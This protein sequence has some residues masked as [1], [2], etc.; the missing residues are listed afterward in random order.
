[1]NENAN[2]LVKQEPQETGLTTPMSDIDWGNDAGDG[3][4][5]NRDFSQRLLLIPSIIILQSDTPF[6]KKTS[7]EYIEGCTD[8]NFFNLSTHE[9]Y[10]GQKK[11]ILIVPSYY[12]CDFEERT[13]PEKEGDRGELIAIHPEKSDIV[14]SS[15]WQNKKFVSP[16]G[17]I[18]HERGNLYGMLLGKDENEF[19]PVLV[20]F[21]SRNLKVFKQ[22]ITQINN[23][24]S[25]C[26]TGAMKKAPC[27]LGIYNFILVPDHDDKFSWWAMKLVSVP[28]GN[29]QM[30]FQ[31]RVTN[32]VLYDTAKAFRMSMLAGESIAEEDHRRANGETSVEEAAV[33]TAADGLP[34]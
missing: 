4:T 33:V 32:P 23:W 2:A 17:N 7:T 30:S 27:Y 12:N 24:I 21:R 14:Q 25:K 29:G 20:R 18:M 28:I 6:C 19:S 1:M 11:G 16:G 8:G 34:F 9:Q 22:L 5:V 10:E 26:T 3:S 13:P 15:Y 31:K